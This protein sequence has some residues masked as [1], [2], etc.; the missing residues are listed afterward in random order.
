M[1]TELKKLTNLTNGSEAINPLSTNTLKKSKTLKNVL[2]TAV[3]SVLCLST[4]SVAM[5]ETYQVLYHI[6][7]KGDNLSKLEN[8]FNVSIKDIKKVNALKTDSINVGDRLLIPVNNIS[9]DNSSKKAKKT[10]KKARKNTSGKPSK[11]KSKSN[12]SKSK[13][14]KIKT[15]K[16]E[17]QYGDTLS[18]IAGKHKITLAQLLDLNNLDDDYRLLGGDILL[19]PKMAKVSAKTAKPKVKKKVK[20]A[21]TVQ[22]SKPKSTKKPKKINNTNKKGTY[23]VQSGDTLENIA[24]K[25]QLTQAKLVELNDIDNVDLLKAG[26]VLIVGKLAKSS[27]NTSLKTAKKPI[28]KSKNQV[29]YT[30]K[31]GDNLISIA[32]LFNV[33]KESLIK[34]NKLENRDY[35]VVGQVL[36]IN[37][38]NTPVSKPRISTTVSNA[39][40]SKSY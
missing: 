38:K 21:T 26:D 40:N 31:K 10:N 27:K 25:F 30:V 22:S 13:N 35:L 1:L 33:S 18:G 8:K 3:L 24:K 20:V 11:S 36:K 34:D 7:E 39:V 14:D 32:K 29:S 28:K 5:A 4:G 12:G 9:V 16:Y 2:A 19:V 17:V 23:T 15:A 6:V 37:T